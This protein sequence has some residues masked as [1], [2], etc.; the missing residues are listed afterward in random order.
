MQIAM[1][2]VFLIYRKFPLI[3]PSIS[4][5]LYVDEISVLPP[6]DCLPI[7]PIAPYI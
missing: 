7:G 5:N 1:C 2:E 4:L 6:A 3:H